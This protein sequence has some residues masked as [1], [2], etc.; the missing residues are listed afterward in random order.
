MQAFGAA[1]TKACGATTKSKLLIPPGQ[2]LSGP[3][4]FE[5]P[6]KNAVEFQL[7]GTVLA[8]TELSGVD[9]WIVFNRITGL[10][11]SGQGTLDGQGKVAWSQNK[12]SESGGKC[13][14]PNVR[15]HTS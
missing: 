7:D 3:V 9:D 12:C 5:G 13:K 14:F 11:I 6:C 8:P 10:T 1:W 4:K 15:S 2:Y